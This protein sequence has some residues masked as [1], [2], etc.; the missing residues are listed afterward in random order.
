MLRGLINLLGRRNIPEE[1]PVLE[2]LGHW[3]PLETSN[4]LPEV[5]HIDI[6]TRLFHT[7]KLNLAIE[8][9]KAHPDTTLSNRKIAE[10]LGISHPVVA[11]AKEILKHDN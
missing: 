8:Y 2:G 7:P 4:Q 5:K 11:Q 10:E 1:N 9:L 6:A 3:K